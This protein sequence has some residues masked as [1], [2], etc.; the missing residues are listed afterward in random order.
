MGLTLVT[1]A[2]SMAVTLA[3]LTPDLDGYEQSTANDSRATDKLNAA[4][5]YFQ[6]QTQRQLIQA[7]WLQTL[8]N[9]PLC[10]EIKIDLQPLSSVTTIKYYNVDGTLTTVSSSDYW[11]DTNNKPPRIVFK[12]TFTWPT[13]EVGRPAGVEITFVAGYANA[14][15]IPYD[16]KTAIKLLASYWYNQTTAVTIASA[17]APTATTPAYGDIPYGVTQIINMYRAD[18]Y[19]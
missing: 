10:N 15:A 2:A 8:D 11:V 5:K 14:A 19:T 7:T 4:I 18:G 1:D 16:V 9:W 12:S 6:N 17:A 3:D 13:V